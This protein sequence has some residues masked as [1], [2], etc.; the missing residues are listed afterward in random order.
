MP[1][2]SSQTL[3]EEIV[4]YLVSVNTING[5]TVR[6]FSNI[7]WDDYIQQMDMKGRY[8]DE[9]TLRA[10]A[11]TFNIRIEIIS[12]L[13]NNGRVYINPE[14]SN[15]LGRVTVGHFAEGQGDHHVCLQIEIADF[16]EIQ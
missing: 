2:R 10:F 6:D 5:D 3:R 1:V 7:P 15:L 13:S 9:L 4:N 16:G 12:T 14:N 11:N 8:V